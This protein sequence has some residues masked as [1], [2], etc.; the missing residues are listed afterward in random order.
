MYLPKEDNFE[1]LFVFEQHMSEIRNQNLLVPPV[2][3]YT[4]VMNYHLMK[5]KKKLYGCK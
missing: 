4:T 5:F 3:V 1:V 2:H